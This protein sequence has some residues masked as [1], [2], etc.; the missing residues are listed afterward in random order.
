VT[1]PRTISDRLLAM[2]LGHRE[3]RNGKREVYRIS[4]GEPLGTFTAQEA[5]DRFLTVKS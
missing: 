2:D 5:V 3:A 1:D 4:T